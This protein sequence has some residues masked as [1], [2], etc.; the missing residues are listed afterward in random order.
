M[1]HGRLQSGYRAEYTYGD[2]IIFDC[3]FRYALLGSDTATCQ[4]DGSWDP[5]PPQCQRSECPQGH[6][7][8]HGC[9]AHGLYSVVFASCTTVACAFV[10]QQLAGD[11]VG[12]GLDDFGPHS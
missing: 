5:P 7:P 6:N 11:D 3:E 9:G 2:T 12:V 8:S 4:E 1:E 10:S